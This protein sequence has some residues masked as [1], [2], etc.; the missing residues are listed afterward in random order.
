[1]L[2]EILYSDRTVCLMLD[3][4]LSDKIC[5]NFPKKQ[6]LVGRGRV[7]HRFCVKKYDYKKRL[8][9]PFTASLLKFLLPPPLYLPSRAKNVLQSCLALHIFKTLLYHIQTKRFKYHIDKSIAIRG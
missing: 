4:A 5:I 7:H 2:Y 3:V 1:M 6:N 9:I 8:R